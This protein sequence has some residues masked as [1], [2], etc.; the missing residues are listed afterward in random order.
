MRVSHTARARRNL[1][2]IWIEVASANPAAAEKLYRRLE[3]R[4]E[5]L[6]RFSEAGRLDRI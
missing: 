6:K 2:E 4:V 1:I 3:T 5:T